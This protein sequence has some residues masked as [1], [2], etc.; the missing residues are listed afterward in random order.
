MSGAT[1][2]LR[3]WRPMP[4]ERDPSAPAHSKAA[5]A[6]QRKR[7]RIPKFPK[8]TPQELLEDKLEALRRQS[9]GDHE[10]LQTH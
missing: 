10:L 6:K 7:G 1:A 9:L 2:P 5:E 4:V 8:P 3:A